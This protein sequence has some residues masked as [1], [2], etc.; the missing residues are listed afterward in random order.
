M[1][2]FRFSIFQTNIVFACLFVLYDCRCH[3]YVYV[4]VYVDEYRIIFMNQ[5]QQQL[6]FHNEWMESRNSWFTKNVWITRSTISTIS[7]INNIHKHQEEYIPRIN[8]II[9]R[10]IIGRRIGRKNKRYLERFCDDEEEERA[11][12]SV[13]ERE[14]SLCAASREYRIEMS[15]VK[16]SEVIAG[17]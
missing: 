12:E 17:K 9:R 3:Y 2:K 13:R 16:W 8:L 5:Q 4:Y 1:R 7:N 11:C 15:E 10:I 6:W 14:S